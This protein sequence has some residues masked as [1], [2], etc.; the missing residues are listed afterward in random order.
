MIEREK[1]ISTEYSA[2]PN[3]SAYLA[4]GCA[5][6]IRIILENRHP[7]AELNRAVFIAFPA[8]PF[9]ASAWPSATVAA[10]AGVPGV[11]IRTAEIDP[12]N[13]PAL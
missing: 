10:A 4:I 6:R 2:G 8:F 3:F 11:P 12:P 1:S 7:K 13:V 5:I 9:L